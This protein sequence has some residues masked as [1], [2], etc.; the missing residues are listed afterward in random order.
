MNYVIFWYVS[1]TLDFLSTYRFVDK[2]GWEMESNPLYKF[3]YN[4][5]GWLGIGGLTFLFG[6]LIYIVLQIANKCGNKVETFVKYFLA[7]FIGIQMWVAI[8]NFFD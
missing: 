3:T 2:Y 8:T 5:I 1:K 7:I 6:A 4:Q